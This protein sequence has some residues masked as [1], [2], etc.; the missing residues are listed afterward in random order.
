MI[1]ARIAVGVL[2]LAH[3]LVHLL[4]LADDVGEFSVD[5]SWLVPD[6][7]RRPVAIGLIVATVVAFGGV[8]LAVWSV[9]GLSAAWP[10]LTV[11]ACG[12]SMALLILFWNRSLVLG[13][14]I[15][16]GLLTVAVMRPDWV[17][18]FLP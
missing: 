3:G 4:Y 14:A 18:R 6:A 13:I 2:L 9:P 16:V 8:A 11:V 7:V 1:L 15:D 10:T 12:L 17:G 5:R